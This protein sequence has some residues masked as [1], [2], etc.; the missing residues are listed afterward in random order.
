[1]GRGTDPF[2]V[3][4]LETSNKLQVKTSQFCTKYFY[5][6]YTLQ[7]RR[8]LKFSGTSASTGKKT[9]CIFSSSLKSTMYFNKLDARLGLD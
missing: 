1:M 8:T 7:V 5:C 6:N 2:P 9:P 3:V 4:A